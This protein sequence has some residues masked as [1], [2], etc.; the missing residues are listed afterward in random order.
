MNSIFKPYLRRFVL[1]FFGDTLVYSK[2]LED[3][4]KHLEIVLTVLRENELY[5]NKGKCQFAQ[6]RVEY[7][8]HLISGRG[9]E[10]DPFESES[11]VRMADT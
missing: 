9:V 3:H 11:N 6:E 7:L 8:G 4:L 5:T 1:V 10:A 2:K